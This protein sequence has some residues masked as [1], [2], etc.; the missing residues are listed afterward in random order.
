[1]ADTI[2]CYG[3]FAEYEEDPSPNHAH[4]YIGA[5]PECWHVYTEVL[6]KTYTHPEFNEVKQLANDTYAA[7]HIG[8]QADRRANQSANLHLIGLYLAFEKNYEQNKILKFRE[9]AA[10]EKAWWPPVVQRKGPKWMTILDVIDAKDDK[11][12][13]AKVKKWGKSVWDEYAD[14]HENIIKTYDEFYK[15]VTMTDLN[16]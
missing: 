2:K 13:C 9:L 1:M 3:C 5:I 14:V 12:Y 7:Q 10:S 6:A 4:P 11:D 15:K 16:A 8:D